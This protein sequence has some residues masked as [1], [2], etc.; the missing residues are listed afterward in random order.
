MTFDFIVLP[1]FEFHS[2]S[3]RIPRLEAGGCS[4]ASSSVANCTASQAICW[5]T[6]LHSFR[7]IVHGGFIFVV[8]VVGIL[9]SGCIRTEEIPCLLSRS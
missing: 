8:V 6:T 1:A 4:I 9:L 7:L 2:T 5:F 3:P